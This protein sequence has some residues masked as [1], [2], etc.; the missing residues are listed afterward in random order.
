M[1]MVLSIMHGPTLF[2]FSTGISI[3]HSDSKNQQDTPSIGKRPVQAVSVAEYTW[4]RWVKCLSGT[5]V[6]WDVSQYIE[7]FGLFYI[8]A[9]DKLRIQINIFHIFPPKCNKVYRYTWVSFNHVCQEGLLLW[10]P[11]Y[12]PLQQS[13]SEMK[14]ALK[15]KNLFPMWRGKFFPFKVDHSSKGNKTNQNILIE[16]SPLNVYRS[17]PFLPPPPP[18][19]GYLCNLWLMCIHNTTCRNMKK[20]EEIYPIHLVYH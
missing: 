14:F 16:L 9:A 15:A 13:P 18:F 2:A 20:Y 5:M 7:L 17:P 10:L 3:K 6:A 8:W 11:I 1:S 4:L 19:S 12:F